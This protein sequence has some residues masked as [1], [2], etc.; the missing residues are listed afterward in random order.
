MK[1]SAVL[2]IIAINKDDSSLKFAF[3]RSTKWGFPI[4][5]AYVEIQNGWKWL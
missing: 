2:L 3:S 4:N 1:Q 5:H